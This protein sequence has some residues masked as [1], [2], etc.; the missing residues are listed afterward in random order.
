MII[1]EAEE[2]ITESQEEENDDRLSPHFRIQINNWRKDWKILNVSKSSFKEL[3]R[4]L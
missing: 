4:K 1:I 3:I 2:Q